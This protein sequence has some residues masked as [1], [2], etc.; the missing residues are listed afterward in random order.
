VK[1]CERAVLHWRT[2]Q[3]KG[4]QKLLVVPGFPGVIEQIIDLPP[5]ATSFTLPLVGGQRQVRIETVID[6]VWISSAPLRLDLTPCP[7]MDQVGP[8]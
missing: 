5:H 2:A 7:Q 4:P 1:R 6:G 3:P 8:R